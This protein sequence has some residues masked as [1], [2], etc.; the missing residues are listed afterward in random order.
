MERD[1]EIG[2]GHREGVW[3]WRGKLERDRDRENGKG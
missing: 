3:K 1:R 2:E